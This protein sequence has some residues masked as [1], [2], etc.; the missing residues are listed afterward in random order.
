VSCGL[1]DVVNLEAAGRPALL[2]H[3]HSFDEAA[4]RQAE[5][6]GQSAIRRAV[7]THPIQDKSEREIRGLAASSVADLVS[8]LTAS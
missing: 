2:V 5:M 4:S 6:L 1:R 8:A 3:T 7:V